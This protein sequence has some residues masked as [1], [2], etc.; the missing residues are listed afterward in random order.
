MLLENFFPL[1]EG[2]SMSDQGTKSE[3]ITIQRK[4]L[5]I[6][7]DKPKYGTFAEIGAGQEVARFFFQAGGANGTIAKSISA[8]DMAYSTAMYGECKRFV[9]EDRLNQMLDAE[10]DMLLKTIGPVRKQETTYFS[11]ANTVAAKSYSYNR[12]FHG[13][14]GIKF[15]RHPG[16]GASK[17]NIHI[18]MLDDDRLSQA[19]ALGIVGVNLIYAAFYHRDEPTEAIKSLAENL[20]NHK[21]EVDYVK[22]DGEGFEHIDNRILCLELVRNKLTNAVMFDPKLG[23]IQPAEALYKKSVL[24]QR[25]SFRPLTHV[26]I[27]MMENALAQFIQEDAVKGTEVFPLMEITLANLLA[28][29]DLNLQDFLARVDIL[30]A[31]GYSV[32][33]SNYV[34]FYRLNSYFANYTK[35]PIGIAMGIK[36]I[37]DIFQE[38]YYKDLEGGIM[39]SF[40]KLFSKNVRLYVYPELSADGKTLIKIQN[41]KAPDALEHLFGFL[42]DR[43]HIVGIKG[44]NKD[45]LTIFSRDVL[46][47][48]GVG[49]TD[50]FNMVP[51]TVAKLICERGYFD[52]PKEAK[53]QVT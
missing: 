13:W 41:F 44:F 35:N 10:Y 37:R 52:W 6:N 22:F 39:E 7:L 32:L 46:V 18:R 15:Q 19:Q 29:G 3:S 45:Y 23:V 28:N 4:A 47:M 42:L 5:K 53:Q 17:I 26:N 25:G 8:Y 40:G 1:G 48:I 43:K 50:W 21:I 27:D 9:C 14:L 12:D 38:E 49:S 11:F 24:V 20:N 34:E 36:N 30:M 16:A 31:L 2:Q 51:P 33:I